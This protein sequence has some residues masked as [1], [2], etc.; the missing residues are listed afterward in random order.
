MSALHLLRRL[1]VLE[2]RFLHELEEGFPYAVVA[3]DRITVGRHHWSILHVKREDSVMK[4]VLENNVF[5][6]AGELLLCVGFIESALVCN[7]LNT[8][9]KSTYRIL[10]YNTLSWPLVEKQS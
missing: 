4:V 10:C 9:G 2:G 5:N 7:G 1:A 8:D 3:V 6:E